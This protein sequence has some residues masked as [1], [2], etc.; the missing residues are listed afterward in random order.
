MAR[1]CDS[2]RE[3]QTY[4]FEELRQAESVFDFGNYALIENAWESRTL[5]VKVGHIHYLLKEGEFSFDSLHQITERAVLESFDLLVCKVYCSDVLANRS[6]IA[7]GFSCVDTSMIYTHDCV[8]VGRSL[9]SASFNVRE[10]EPDDQGAAFSLA[11]QSFSAHFG[12]FHQ[13]PNIELTR[14]H[15]IYGQ[16]V[17]SS[18][19]G[20][21]DKILVAEEAGTLL[22]LSIWRYGS[23]LEQRLLPG[24]AHYSLGF[25][26]TQAMRNGIFSALTQAGVQL[27][28]QKG[29]RI[30]EG[31]THAGNIPVQRVYVKY[32]W[33]PADATATYH[34]WLKK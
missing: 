22:G 33:K 30:I 20:Y 27:L 4:Y 18:F 8:Q 11:E 28:Q 3:W 7:A 32:G 15:G 12:R 26:S 13:D 23:K 1:S 24:L 14:A 5:A 21:A 19:A 6:L 2:Y 25:V 29:Y 34:L 10:A 17:R 9:P 16:W 31:P